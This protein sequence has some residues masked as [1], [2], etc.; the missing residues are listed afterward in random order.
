MSTPAATSS[1]HE[2]SSSPDRRDVLF[3][4][5]LL[6]SKGYLG[7]PK[8]WNEYHRLS[9]PHQ[10]LLYLQADGTEAAP[11]PIFSGTDW[12]RIVD[13]EQPIALFADADG[14]VSSTKVLESLTIYL[15][16]VK[17]YQTARCDVA[18]STV[19]LTLKSEPPATFE[20]Q[21]AV[22]V[23]DAAHQLQYYLLPNGTGN[24][25]RKS[26]ADMT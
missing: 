21:I 12:L 16:G 8:L 26:A 25:T 6:V 1:T 20:L 7:C 11:S 17:H 14:Y 18:S 4:D 24:W 22:P 10:L 9:M 19:Q 5:L 2:P 15:S 3:Q 23:H 13:L